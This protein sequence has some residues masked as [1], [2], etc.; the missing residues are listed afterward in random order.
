M[1]DTQR[2]TIPARMK[3]VSETTGFVTSKGPRGDC[4]EWYRLVDGEWKPTHILH[5]ENWMLP[6]G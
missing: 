5:E 4:F 2:M 3:I 1:E 6:T